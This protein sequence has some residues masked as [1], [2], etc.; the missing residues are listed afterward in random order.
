MGHTVVYKTA[1]GHVFLPVVVFPCQYHSSNVTYSSSTVCRSYQNKWVTHTNLSKSN[2]LSKTGG[3]G[4][5]KYFHHCLQETVSWLRI[6]CLSPQKLGF[7]P[8][9]ARDI[10]GWQTELGLGCLTAVARRGGGGSLGVQTPS[11]NSEGPPKSCQTQPNCEK[12][13]IAEFRTP[14]PQ[15]VRIKAVKF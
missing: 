11:R 10:R 9:P 12:L 1:L 6:V 5:E 3:H 8:R 15:D 13:K 14:T 2:D 7:D 4:V